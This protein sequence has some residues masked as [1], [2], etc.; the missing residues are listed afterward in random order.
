MLKHGL[1]QGTLL[2]VHGWIACYNI[3][4]KIVEKCDTGHAFKDHKGRKTQEIIALTIMDDTT[5]TINGEKA[6]QRAQKALRLHQSA[7]KILGGCCNNTKLKHVH[8]NPSTTETLKT[9]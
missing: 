8:V 3:V 1:N 2:A 7:F 6:M 4:L 5:L 9:T